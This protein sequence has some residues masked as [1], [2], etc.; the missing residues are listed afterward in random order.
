MLIFGVFKMLEIKDLTVEVGGKIV[1]KDFSLSIEKGETHVLLGPNGSG[2]TSLILTI[3]GFPRYRVVKGEII[4]K[5][6]NITSLPIHERVKLGIGVAFQHP[7]KLR[8]VTLNEIV[9]ICMGELSENINPETLKL[10]EEMKI[11][12][13]FLFRDV[14]VGFSGGEIKKS[15]ILQLLAQNPD[16]V[17]LDEPDSGVDVENI[18]LIGKLIGKL[19]QRDVMPSMRE[20]SGLIIT[21]AGHIL[22]YVKADRA[23]VMLNGRKACSGETNEILNQIMKKGYEECVRKCQKD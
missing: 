14:N 9:N 20:K 8:G 19:L 4:F 10:V 6:R 16:F 23:H 22:N 15:E 5:G 17:M 7:P 11:P 2:K 13:E 18:A 12:K 1:L 21:H 3:L